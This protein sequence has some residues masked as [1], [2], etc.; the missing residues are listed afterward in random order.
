MQE[1]WVEPYSRL[2]YIY[3]TK[4]LFKSATVNKSGLHLT[5]VVFPL[6]PIAPDISILFF[7]E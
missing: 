6:S 5:S 7:A 4:Q 1:Q 2:E 3:G